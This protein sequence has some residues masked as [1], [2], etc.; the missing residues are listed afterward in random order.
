M[1]RKLLQWLQM[2]L[3]SP[4]E[5]PNHLLT[6]P[7]LCSLAW[8]EYGA[9][10][11]WRWP[12]SWDTQGSPHIVWLIVPSLFL[13]CS[14]LHAWVVRVG[15]AFG[16]S[17]RLWSEH[18]VHTIYN[19]IQNYYSKA[20]LSN[21]LSIFIWPVLSNGSWPIT[22][23]VDHECW[24]HISH[25]VCPPPGQIQDLPWSHGE[26]YW[27]CLGIEWVLIQVYV[28]QIICVQHWTPFQ[29]AFGLCVV[30]E[31]VILRR[32]Y[33]PSFLTNNLIHKVIFTINVPLSE[34]TL[35]TNPA[36]KECLWTLRLWLL[37]AMNNC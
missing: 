28:V 31:F 3:R 34:S 8:V 23:C 22:P 19:V 6:T 2:N 18:L 26:R 36:V 7:M 17:E 24:A 21:F 30:E 25:C 37:L 33:G 9:W 5:C 10:L 11:P 14:S 13:Q 16:A 4:M 15:G 32:E 12:T 35:C 1:W 29:G 27:S 20:S